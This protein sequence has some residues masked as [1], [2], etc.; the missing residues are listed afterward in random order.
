KACLVTASQRAVASGPYDPGQRSPLHRCFGLSEELLVNKQ[1]RPV[2]ART[3]YGRLA[4]AVHRG[5]QLFRGWAMCS[6]APGSMGS[7]GQALAELLHSR[8]AAD[9]PL[10]GLPPARAGGR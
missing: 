2:V 5:A 7:P 9:L 10:A 8:R 4:A 6:A 1:G 3:V